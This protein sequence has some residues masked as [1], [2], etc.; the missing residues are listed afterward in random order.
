[1]RRRCFRILLAVLMSVTSFAGCEPTARVQ[2][3]AAEHYRF[4]QSYLASE[5]YP[6]AEQEIRKALALQADNAEYFGLLAL[7][8]QAQGQLAPAEEAYRSALQQTAVP[9]ATL[10]NYSTLLLLRNREDEAIALAQKALQAPGYNK[11]AL[12]YTNIGLAYLQ[13]DLLPQAEAHFRKALEYQANLP[14]VYHN[15]GLMYDRMRRFPEAVQAFQEAIRL[16]PSYSAA[17]HGL[18]RVWLGSGQ[19]EKA[20][21][22][23]ENVIALAPNSPLAIDSREQLKRMTP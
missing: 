19:R 18:G 16:R 7:I 21:E 5:S 17:H 11:P 13:K 8:Y 10:V 1:M 3:R 14:E 2:F 6:L 9:P 23:F 22:A 15:M 4:A 12:A 20:R